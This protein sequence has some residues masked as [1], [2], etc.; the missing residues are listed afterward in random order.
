MSENSVPVEVRKRLTEWLGLN[1]CKIYPPIYP[2][3]GECKTCYEY[4]ETVSAI[5]FSTWA[6]LGALKEKLVAEGLWEEFCGYARYY[7]LANIWT[8][9]FLDWFLNPVRF[10]L[11]VDE[12]LRRG[13]K[14]K[15]NN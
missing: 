6:D 13:E 7:E 2:C 15:R 12:F 4:D 3:T 9:Q 8:Y 11:L 5:T 14:G 10:A 1:H